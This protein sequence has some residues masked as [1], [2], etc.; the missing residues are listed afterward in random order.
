MTN[1]PVPRRLIDSLFALTVL[2]MTTA[3]ILLFAIPQNVVAET[4]ALMTLSSSVWIGIYYFRENRG[5]KASG[6]WHVLACLFF[7]LGL[8]R[9]IL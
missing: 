4:L 3:T 7:A 8:V 2:V 6:W 1:V 5:L 9:Q